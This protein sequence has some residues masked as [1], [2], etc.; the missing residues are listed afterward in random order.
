M[1]SAL[2]HGSVIHDVFGTGSRSA[3]STVSHPLGSIILRA[4][5][6]LVIQRLSRRLHTPWPIPPSCEHPGPHIPGRPSLSLGPQNG[7]QR[8]VHAFGFAL[9]AHPSGGSRRLRR[10]QDGIGH[11]TSY[12][13]GPPPVLGILPTSRILG[14]NVEVEY[15]AVP[16][17][18]GISKPDLSRQIPDQIGGFLSAQSVG[19]RCH[20]VKSSVSLNSAA[21]EIPSGR[22]DLQFRLTACCGFDVKCQVLTSHNLIGVRSFRFLPSSRPA[23]TAHLGLCSPHTLPP[24]RPIPTGDKR[25]ASFHKLRTAAPAFAKTVSARRTVC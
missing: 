17:N 18:D 14:Q 23:F 2:T 9:T 16:G 24:S 19:C 6:L 22:Q 3:C 1:K 8:T 11:E 20:K 5:P 13:R 15:R 7:S 4:P 25:Q 21:Q 12:R 10:I